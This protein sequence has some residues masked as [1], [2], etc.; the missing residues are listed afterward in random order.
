MSSEW[1][2]ELARKVYGIENY[3][4]Q[5]IIDID[6]EG[7]LVIKIGDE[8]IRI[9][10]LMDHYGLDIAYI[11]VLPAI[12]K[13]M[14]LV[15]YS[16]KNIAETYG[17]KGGFIPVF[18]MKVNA[19]PLVIETIM[20]YGEQYQWGFNTGSLGEVKLLER[21]AG[22]YSPRLLIFDGVVTEHTV[23]ELIKLVAKGWRVVVD[24][25]SEHDLD[26]LSRYPELEL[27]IRVKPIVKLHGK[28]SG[29]VGLGSKF[30]MT[31]NTIIKLRAEYK[32]LLERA[33]LLHMHPGSQVYK[34]IDIRNYIG[35]VK[36]VYREIMD[37]GFTN[38]KM[39]DLGG[40]MAY[41][42][43]DARDGSEE[44]PDYTIVDYFKEIISAFREVDPNPTIIYEGGRFIVSSHRL[45]VSKTVDIRSHS[46]IHALQEQVMSIREVNSLSDVK[47]L[48]QNIE[49]F[50]NKLRS[51][52]PFDNGKR[53]IYEELVALL[54]EDVP[55]KLAE[56]IIAGKISFDE[57]V[58][59]QRVLRLLTTPS[60]R[61]VL[62]MSIFADLPD[63][64]LVDQYFPIIPAQR[65]NEK[66]HVLASI[67]DLTC[68]SMGEVKEFFS[69]GLGIKD[70]KPVFTVLDSRLIIAPG[71]K[72][73]LRGVP[74]HLPSRGEN[75]YLVFLD[76]GAY[77]DTL[78]MRHN[79]IYGA[80]E[81]VVYEDNGK[82]KIEIQRH[83]ELYS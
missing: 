37:L 74:I 72:L 35:E 11:R 25:E 14:E 63:I 43:V 27:G 77:Q 59:D 16:Y 66:P 67:S 44:S 21:L 60:K 19:T 18:P 29:S 33:T 15:Y 22:R 71:M 13:A 57:V 48:I 65:L 39:V 49:V 53:E 42:Y 20:K 36:Q 1:S 28:W 80:P 68:D 7:Y 54:R 50:I 40:G 79:L 6:D 45:V 62:N 8:K 69:N 12:R 5:S 23:Q 26:I 56:L 58:K 64:V 31:T 78:A 61:L 82:I 38:V 32:F 47:S 3:V 24:V 46:A 34:L 83:E 4:R 55:G 73:K 10:E 17:Y 76:T 30:G 2:I 81:I 75:Y 52:A 9:K 70:T 41:P 51:E